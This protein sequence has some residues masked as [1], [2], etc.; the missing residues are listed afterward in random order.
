[1]ASAVAFPV[2]IGS[3]ENRGG[4]PKKRRK[5]INEIIHYG[6]Q[7]WLPDSHSLDLESSESEISFISA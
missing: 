3:D 7:T 5:S 4:S 1:M 2:D 6:G